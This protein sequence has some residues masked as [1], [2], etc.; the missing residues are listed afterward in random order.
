M[1]FATKLMCTVETDDFKQHLKNNSESHSFRFFC[2]L[3]C[4]VVFWFVFC[5]FVCLFVCSDFFFFFFFACLF[6]AKTHVDDDDVVL[7][8]LR[9]QA[10]I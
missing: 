9:Y 8:A 1:K 4:F 6:V 7:N 3:V 10:D 2:F 5:L